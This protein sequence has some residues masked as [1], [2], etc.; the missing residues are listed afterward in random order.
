VLIGLGSEIDESQ[1]AELDDLNYGGL[2]TP[3]GELVDLWDA[4]NAAEMTTLDTVFDECVSENSII[5][6]SATITDSNGNP[7]MPLRRSSYADGL[8][9][10]I[11]FICSPDSTSFTVTIPDV[12]SFTQP[13]I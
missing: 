3:E 4:R 10:L 6:N 5:A 12:G 1:M 7:V 9:A 13:L 2:K 11:E 8:P